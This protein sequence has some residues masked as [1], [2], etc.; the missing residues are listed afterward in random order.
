MRCLLVLVLSFTIC[1]CSTPSRVWDGEDRS[2]VWTAMV[3]VAHSPEYKSPDPRRRWLV[4]QNDVVA[5]ADSGRIEIHRKLRRSLKLP[6]QREQIDVRE[7]FIDITLLPTLPAETTFELLNE[8]FIP[9][10]S[11]DE[12][13]LYFDQVE[14]L[15]NTP[16]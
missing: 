13:D 4:A 5:H 6:R 3:A 7:Y 8:K 9:V 16:Q 12:A 15:L 2:V 11:L 10:R 14:S 1:G